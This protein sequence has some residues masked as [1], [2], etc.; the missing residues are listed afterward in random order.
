MEN[1]IHFIWISPS[2]STSLPEDIS[3]NLDLWRKFH[4]DF[5]QRIWGIAEIMAL[6]GKNNLDRVAS[7]IFACRL[8]AMKSDIARLLIMSCEGGVYSDLK[9]SPRR[10]FLG[11]FA[12]NPCPL[13]TEYPNDIPAANRGSLSY[14]NGFLVGPQGHAFFHDCL[15][16][17]C[18]NVEARKIAPVFEITGGRVLEDCIGKPPRGDI[19][20]MPRQS[21]WG[22]GEDALMTRISASYNGSNNAQHWVNQQTQG[23][24]YI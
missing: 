1:T 23:D 11:T 18:R 16:N 13:V 24:L 5:E 4:P 15:D 2:D 21:V 3:S 12:A 7:C 22:D 8:L 19:L 9:N 20:L 10:S 17:A 6:A 14:F